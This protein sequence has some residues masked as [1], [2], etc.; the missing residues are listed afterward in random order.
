MTNYF[1]KAI[2][3]L[4]IFFK[5]EIKTHEDIFHA[6]KT[7]FSIDSGCIYFITPENLRV[8]YSYPTN[9]TYKNIT[10]NQSQQDKIFDTKNNP[11]I[12]IYDNKKSTLVERL[13]VHSIVYGIILIERAV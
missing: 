10:I 1:K 9:N 2:S 4:E 8:E 3:N 7:I 12:K 13:C 5:G 11:T 6:L